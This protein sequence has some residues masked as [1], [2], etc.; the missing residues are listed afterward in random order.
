MQLFTAMSQFVSLLGQAQERQSTSVWAETLLAEERRDRSGRGA[1]SIMDSSPTTD[2]G[3][4]MARM[5]SP[6]FGAPTLAFNKP[7]SR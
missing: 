3:P 2:S 6:P 5:R 7:S 1:P 4:R